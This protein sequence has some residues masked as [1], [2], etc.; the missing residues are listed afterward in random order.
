MVKI[1]CKHAAE[2]KL[3]KCQ[4]CEIT[5]TTTVIFCQTGFAQSV[6]TL[7][8]QPGSALTKTLRGAWEFNSPG[9]SQ[10]LCMLCAW[11]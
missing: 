6:L 11:T 9:A 7:A 4:L 10:R 1:T 3:S 2:Q 8:N 5:Y